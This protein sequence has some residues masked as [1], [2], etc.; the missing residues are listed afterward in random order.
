MTEKMTEFMNETINLLF[1]CLYIWIIFTAYRY[2]KYKYQDDYLVNDVNNVKNE[3]NKL[4]QIM[5]K[6]R[7]IIKV[8]DELTNDQTNQ[9]KK[10]RKE[11][12]KINNMLYFKYEKNKKTDLIGYEID[13]IV[14]E[15]NNNDTNSIYNFPITLHQQNHI[16]FPNYLVFNQINLKKTKLSNNNHKLEFIGDDI[17]LISN[18]LARFLKVD[19]GTCMEFNDAYENVYNY[20]QENDIINI[21]EDSNLCKLFGINENGDYEFTDTALIEIL[22]QLLE[23]HFRNII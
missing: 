9:I 12:R 8:G 19:I 22:K 20:I 4:L 7:N 14:D 13:D 3:Q 21:S 1:N 16:T 2:I 6:L 11:I 18:E 15:E 5:I 23:P 10:I 17:K